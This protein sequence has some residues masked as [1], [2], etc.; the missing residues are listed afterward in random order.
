MVGGRVRPTSV[1]ARALSRLILGTRERRVKLGIERTHPWRTP[2]RGDSVEE[3]RSSG[4]V[5]T[6]GRDEGV[7]QGRYGWCRGEPKGGPCPASG[8]RRVEG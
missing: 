3:G 5:P 2:W 6:R 1:S 4:V 7:D 8:G